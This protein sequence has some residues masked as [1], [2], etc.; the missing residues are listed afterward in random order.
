MK[1]N[2]TRRFRPTLDSLPTRLA[3]AGIC[4]A[5]MPATELDAS[6]TVITPPP[7]FAPPPVSAP[8]VATPPADIELLVTSLPAHCI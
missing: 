3:P 4:F 1:T 5:P 2:R 8:V 7:E 6:L